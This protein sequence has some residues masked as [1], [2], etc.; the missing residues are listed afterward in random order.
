MSQSHQ[1]RHFS[2]GWF[3]CERKGQQLRERS[4]VK[5]SGGR[6]Y[7][8]PVYNMVEV[9]MGYFVDSGFFLK[10]E[11]PISVDTDT[12]NPGRVS[13]QPISK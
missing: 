10:R 2:T 6:N 7:C 12:K 13:H 5:G 1:Y 11:Q 3:V 4:R 8:P 9:S